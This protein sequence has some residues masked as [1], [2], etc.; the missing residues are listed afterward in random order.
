MLTMCI[1][2]TQ[3]FSGGISTI[4]LTF[5]LTSGLES[6]FI[7]N[8]GPS[9]CYVVGIVELAH[10]TKKEQQAGANFKGSV[11]HKLPLLCA[12]GALG[13]WLIAAYTCNNLM[14]PDPDDPDAW[15]KAMLWPQKKGKSMTY[16]NHRQRC[17]Q[18][19]SGCENILGDWKKVTH[20]AR[21]FGAQYGDE[22]GLTD[23]VRGYLFH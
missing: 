21:S 5:G 20:A 8:A 23:E 12:Q 2:R 3:N 11:R 18:L 7:P 16:G 10:K 17:K 6:T 4:I 13:R 15:N 9:P 19:F 22:V 1:S 14:F